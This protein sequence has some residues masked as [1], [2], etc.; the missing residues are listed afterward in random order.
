MGK[1][2]TGA[3]LVAATV[4]SAAAPGAA[5]GQDVGEAA[6]EVADVAGQWTLNRALSDDPDDQLRNVRG[7]AQPPGGSRRPDQR[8]PLDVV[9]RAMEGF[10]ITQTDSTVAIAYPDRE[11]V[12]FTDGRKQ[13]FQV[14]GARELEYRA[15]RDGDKL[16]VERRLEGGATLTEA[17]SVHAGTGRLHVLTRLAGE[18]LPRTI[19]FVR[20]YDPSDRA[21][22]D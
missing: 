12:L 20:V 7:A 22:D 17:Y 13:K 2:G 6:V 21:G 16:L 1:N 15:W 8:S 10:A 18:R 5:G 19:S 9:R 14:D 4:L 3:W 11:V